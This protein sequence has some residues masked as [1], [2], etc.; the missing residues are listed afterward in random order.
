MDVGKVAYA[1]ASVAEFK[2]GC[3]DLVGFGASALSASAH[4]EYGLNNSVGANVSLVR[5][6]GNV[7]PAHVGV[8]LNFDTN[9]SIGV[10]GVGASFLG[11]GFHLG[12]RLQIKTPFF[13]FSFN[14]F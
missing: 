8:G 11:M 5:A 7:G 4:A 6:Q 2:T 12:P 10:N 1:G 14:L 9:A 3:G 13:D